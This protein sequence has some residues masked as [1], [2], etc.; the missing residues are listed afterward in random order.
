MSDCEIKISKYL[1]LVL[2]HQ[3]EKIG[4]ELSDSGWASV[5]QL[6]EASRKHG[7]EFT[8]EALQHAVSNNDNGAV[9]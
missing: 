2:R 7:I 5:E 1:S 3:P 9:R 4:L 8:L 6:I